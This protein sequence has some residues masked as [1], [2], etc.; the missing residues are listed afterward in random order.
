MSTWATED[1][2][3]WAGEGERGEILVDLC[4]LGILRTWDLMAGEGK[5]GKILGCP[6]LT[7]LKLGY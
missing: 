5:R 7:Y 4:Q 3:T 6:K 2:S 1:M